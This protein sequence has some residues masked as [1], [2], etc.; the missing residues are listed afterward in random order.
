MSCRNSSWRWNS[1]TVGFLFE[2]ETA[3][4]FLIIQRKKQQ[5]NENKCS[6][7][8][9]QNDYEILKEQK[10]QLNLY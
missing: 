10:V 2:K 9:N 3:L 1:Q 5:T 8:M 7:N 6:L 4:V